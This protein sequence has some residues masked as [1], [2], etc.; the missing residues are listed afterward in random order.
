MKKA[1]FLYYQKNEEKYKEWRGSDYW[2][3]SMNLDNFVDVIMHL[4][5]LGV[6]KA[7]KELLLLWM[8]DQETETVSNC[9]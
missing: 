4:L 6:A 1:I 7:S 9:D 5:F 3:S 8:K 2:N